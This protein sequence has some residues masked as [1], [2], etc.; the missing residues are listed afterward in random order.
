MIFHVDVWNVNILSG[1][2]MTSWQKYFN[3]MGS[4][5]SGFPGSDFDGP[6]TT[7]KPYPQPMSS[8]M[9]RAADVWAVRGS[10]ADVGKGYLVY[11]VP[12]PSREEP[13]RCMNNS[14]CRRIHTQHIFINYRLK[15]FRA[16]KFNKDPN[17]SSPMWGNKLRSTQPLS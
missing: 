2:R 16:R 10:K 3:G 7:Q 8:C 1:E 12:S 17:P 13:V 6:T 14:S 9:P 15:I 11:T 5:A 4:M